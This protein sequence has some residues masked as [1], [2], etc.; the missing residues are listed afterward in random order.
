M[1]VASDKERIKDATKHFDQ[2][3]KSTRTSTNSQVPLDARINVCPVSQI[4]GKA[5]TVA[6]S[7]NPI[8]GQR[9]NASGSAFSNDKETKGGSRV[10]NLPSCK[11]GQ[12]RKVVELSFDPESKA[13]FPHLQTA[14]H[15]GNN[16]NAK[17]VT[18]AKAKSATFC[19]AAP[20]VASSKRILRFLATNFEKCYEPRP[21][22]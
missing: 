17:S 14:D 11:Q 3:T 2:L 16:K 19:H 18:L 10:H 9:A 8:S 12:V 13:E 20:S 5:Q 6:R 22:A 4:E 1:L 7:V 15:K 21:K